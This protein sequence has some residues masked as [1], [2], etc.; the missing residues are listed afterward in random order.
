M[1]LFALCIGATVAASLVAAQPPIVPITAVE[2]DLCTYEWAVGSKCTMDG[3]CTI[4]NN[5]NG[6]GFP[7][8]RENKICCGIENEDEECGSVPATCTDGKLCGYCYFPVTQPTVEPPPTGC[9]ENSCCHEGYTIDE[10]LF[11]SGGPLYYL[12]ATNDG[13]ERLV[14]WR[15]LS[16]SVTDVFISP[17]VDYCPFPRT[18]ELTQQMSIDITKNSSDPQDY[19]CIYLCCPCCNNIDISIINPE[20]DDIPDCTGAIASYAKPADVHNFKGPAKLCAN[21]ANVLLLTHD[22]GIVSLDA[23]GSALRNNRVSIG[24]PRK[25]GGGNAGYQN[26]TSDD[27][28]DEL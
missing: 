25:Q 13:A 28:R 27:G 6:G 11:K 12:D 16:L 3:D 14:A 15:S 4:E 22:L 9:C 1:K 23:D 7:I 18:G 26:I 19:T 2:V 5:P 20:T 17:E 10:N 8:E 24:C 21:E